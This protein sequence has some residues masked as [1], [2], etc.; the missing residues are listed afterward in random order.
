[1]N[2]SGLKEKA[3]K[4]LI[5]KGEELYLLLEFDDHSTDFKLSAISDDGKK[6]I[7]ILTW[8]GHAKT[9]KDDILTLSWAKDFGFKGIR[10]EPIKFKKEKA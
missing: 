5:D 3:I 7:S 4:N 2:D 6:R 9:A 10:W 8:K 1:M